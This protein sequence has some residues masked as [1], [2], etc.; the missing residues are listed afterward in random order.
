MAA[1]MGA[2]G[3][4]PCD[5]AKNKN[6]MKRFNVR[7]LS[8]RFRGYPIGTVAYYGPDAKTA[9]KAVTA[10]IKKEGEGPSLI[11]RWVSSNVIND[12]KIQEKIAAFLKENGAKSI[13]ATEGT[14]GC[15]HEEGK[16][17]PIGEDCPFCPFWK[18]KQ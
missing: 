1:L 5:T 10:I 12:K 7:C 3:L 14:I 13:I 16:D 4:Q 9:V 18:G 17:F 2:A 11:K 6:Y 8:T 15:I